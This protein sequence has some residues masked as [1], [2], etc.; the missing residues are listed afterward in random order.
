MF[1]TAK[2]SELAFESRDVWA[3]YK[4]A[5]GDDVADCGIDFIL[6]RSV[7]CPQ[8]NEGHFDYSDRY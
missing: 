8:I 7:L 6:Y 5:I 3:A 2:S 4:C 1:C